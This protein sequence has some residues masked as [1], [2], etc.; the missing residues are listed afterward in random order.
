MNLTNYVAFEIPFVEYR[1]FYVGFFNL[2]VIH[3]LQI[4][5]KVLVEVN[6]GAKRDIVFYCGFF[7]FAQH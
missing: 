6:L 4:D 2:L 5:K 1:D 7:R 3:L